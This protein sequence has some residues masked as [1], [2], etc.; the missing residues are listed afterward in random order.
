MI[1]C[2]SKENSELSEFANT[3]KEINIHF[4]SNCKSSLKHTY[5]Q[6][7][8]ALVPEEKTNTFTIEHPLNIH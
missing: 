6:L 8:F 1:D 2:L 3:K 7:Q 5:M 4:I